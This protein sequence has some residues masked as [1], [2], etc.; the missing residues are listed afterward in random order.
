MNYVSF[1]SPVVFQWRSYITVLNTEL[2]RAFYG[3]A[4]VRVILWGELLVY[5]QIMAHIWELYRITR[6]W[7]QQQHFISLTCDLK[8]AYS[9]LHPLSGD[10]TC[11]S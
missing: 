7:Q 4:E 9:P 8:P 6:E 11:V 3:S 10:A 1:S 5:V 2:G